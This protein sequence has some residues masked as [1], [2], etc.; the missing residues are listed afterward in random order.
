MLPFVGREAATLKPPRPM[1]RDK[2]IY[3]KLIWTAMGYFDDYL[4]PCLPAS[5][6]ACSLA[7]V[8]NM[9]QHL[10]SEILLHICLCMLLVSMSQR[11]RL[12][13]NSQSSIRKTSFLYSSHR[14]MFT[15]SLE[16]MVYGKICVLSI[17]DCKA[18]AQS[19]SSHVRSLYRSQEPLNCKK[20]SP[21]L[22]NL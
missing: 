5:Q 4:T 21:A 10:P 11:F 13:D 17:L 22:V 12:A 2:V 20:L 16:M 3:S 9:L 6:Q 14:I 15:G 7:F 19:S 8:A 18:S 1:T